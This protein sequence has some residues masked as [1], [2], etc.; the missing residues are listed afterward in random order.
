MRYRDIVFFKKRVT[1]E[2]TDDQK[3]V[4]K[5]SYFSALSKTSQKIVLACIQHYA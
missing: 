3:K 4:K 1:D 5:M 2:N